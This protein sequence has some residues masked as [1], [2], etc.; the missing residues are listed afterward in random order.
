MLPRARDGLTCPFLPMRAYPTMARLP[1]SV[2]RDIVGYAL[3]KTLE[4]EGPL[5]ALR[6]AMDFYNRYNVDLNN[7]IHHSDRGVQYCSNLY[8]GML[9]K[10]HINISM[11]PCG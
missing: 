4:A 7:L 10:H 5:K 6:M 9:K 2:R 8:V 1:A 3:C 11:T